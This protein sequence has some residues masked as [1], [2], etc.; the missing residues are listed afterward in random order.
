MNEV[1]ADAAHSRVF[2]YLYRD[3]P[4]GAALRDLQETMTAEEFYA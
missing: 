4:R 2:L 3:D 1:G